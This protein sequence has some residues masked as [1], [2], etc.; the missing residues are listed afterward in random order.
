MT[1]RHINYAHTHTYTT[2]THTH[3]QTASNVYLGLNDDLWGPWLKHFYDDPLQ[4]SG[5]KV[6]YLPGINTAPLPLEA[7]GPTSPH[8][9]TAGCALG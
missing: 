7:A 5:Q 1:H 3:S 6:I 4:L 2:H 9:I 8:F